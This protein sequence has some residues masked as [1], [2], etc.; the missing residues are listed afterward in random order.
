[1][2]GSGVTTLVISNKE[3]NDFMKIVK[4]L[5]E[6]GL[7]MKEVSKTIKNEVKGQKGQFLGILLGTLSASLFGNLLTGKGTIRAGEDTVRACQDF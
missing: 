7:L 1:M 5:E 2:F 6:F 3:I 4:F